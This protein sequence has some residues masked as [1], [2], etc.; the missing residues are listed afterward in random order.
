MESVKQAVQSFIAVMSCRQEGVP[1][2][3]HCVAA[4][5]SLNFSSESPSNEVEPVCVVGNSE[6]RLGELTEKETERLEFPD[7][8]AEPVSEKVITNVDQ[9]ILTP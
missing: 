5:N 7:R 6:Q 4:N 2:S 1:V 9:R 3:D 8:C